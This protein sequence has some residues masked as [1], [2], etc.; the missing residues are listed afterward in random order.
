M[1]IS[2]DFLN[3]A[4]SCP[5]CGLSWF[6][7]SGLGLGCH[8]PYPDSYRAWRRAV[9]LYEEE[10]QRDSQRGLLNIFTPT[11]LGGLAVMAPP[12]LDVTFTTFQKQHGTSFRPLSR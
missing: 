2:R 8:P 1:M 7:S 11:E 3:S 12:S 6:Q 9:W 4:R 10:S 5:R